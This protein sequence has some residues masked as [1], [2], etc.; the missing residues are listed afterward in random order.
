MLI[1]WKDHP[2]KLDPGTP[3]SVCICLLIYRFKQHSRY[4]STPTHSV[5]IH[6]RRFSVPIRRRSS[7]NKVNMGHIT[8]GPIG[9]SRSSNSNA[10]SSPRNSTNDRRHSSSL[11]GQSPPTHRNHAKPPRVSL[12]AWFFIIFSLEQNDFW[13]VFIVIKYTAFQK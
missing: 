6:A 7:S 11:I 2:I 10:S 4:S 8:M 1:G 13:V 12:Q 3:S 5:T 9:Q